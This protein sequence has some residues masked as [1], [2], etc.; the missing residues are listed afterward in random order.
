MKLRPYQQEAIDAIERAL[1]RGISRSL[2]ALPTG[3]GKT[4]VFSHLIKKRGGKALILAHRDELLQ[5]AKDKLTTVAPELAGSVGLVKGRSD[6]IDADIVIA[7]VQ[8]LARRPRLARLPRRFDTVI[9]DEAHHAAANTYRRILGHVEPSPLVAGFTATPE[10]SDKRRLSSVFGEIVYAKSIEEMIRSGYLCDLQGIR[11][12]VDVD[13]DQVKQSRGDFQ[14][15]DLGRALSASGTP[16]EVLQAFKEHASERR[17]VIFCPTVAL[18]HEMADTFRADGIAAGS[19]D[20]KTPIDER[21]ATLAALGSGEVQVVTNVGVLTEGFDEPSISCVIMAA[22]TRSRVKYVQVVGRGLRLYPG[23]DDCLVLDVAGVSDKLSIQSLPTLFALK[24]PPK[25]KERVTEAVDRER[26][27]DEVQF[28]EER[29]RKAREDEHRQRNRSISFFT[30][31]RLHWLH[32]GER[33]VLSAGQDELLV[34]DQETKEQTSWRV[35]LVGP[36]KARIVARGLDLGYAQGA[37]EE[38]VRERGITSLVDREAPWREVRASPGQRRFMQK[39]GVDASNP[40]RGEAA[41][42]ITTALAERRLGLMDKALG[43]REAA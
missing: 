24:A 34:L 3:S 18:A 12:G 40:T 36:D 7:S 1:A 16:R 6:E 27:E 13:L 39:L 15:D 22:P 37:A 2:I 30:R 35:L 31:D 41:D 20:G 25:P 28:G 21:R 42:L 9:V 5:Q 23:K 26:A 10:R 32:I 17:T 11:V 43:E 19:V 33:W 4:V 29:R 14:A 38:A 8:T